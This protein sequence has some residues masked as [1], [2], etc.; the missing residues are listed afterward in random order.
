MKIG[1][2]I[3]GSPFDGNTLEKKALGGTESSVIYMSRE[4]AGLG[5]HVNVYTNCENSGEYDGVIYKKY[6]EFDTEEKFDVIVSVRELEPLK[7]A[8]S[9]IRICW[10]PDAYDQ[11]II[12]TRIHDWPHA[13]R[14]FTVSR[15]QTNGLIQYYKIPKEKF[16]ITRNGVYRPDFEMEAEKNKNKLIY[17]SAP[18]RGLDIL[19]DL[20]PKIREQIKNAELFV[21]G[22]L[23]DPKYESLYKKAESIEGI[24]IM[25]N[26]SRQAFVQEF[27]NSYIMIYPNHF[28]ETS[29]I[30][31]MES[32][33]AGTPIVSSNLGALPETVKGGVLISGNPHSKK[34]QDDFVGETVSLLQNRTKWL[35]LSKKGREYI[36]KNN[37]WDKIAK[38]WME[39]FNELLSKT[40]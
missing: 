27:L 10:V 40:I 7:W 35:E 5:N 8:D 2:Y 20:F 38:E 28:P 24:R 30:A 37:S 3:T 31:A 9:K 17:A 33:A 36:L 4:L 39:E 29:C 12:Q 25:R 14:L 6:Q 32:Q 23:T 1:F 15:W 18:Y 11:T 34:Y 13:D 22:Y 21:F 26:I 16:F 19:I